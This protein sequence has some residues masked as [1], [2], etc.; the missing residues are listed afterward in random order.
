MAV[1]F[2]AEQYEKEFKPNRMQNWEIPKQFKGKVSSLLNLFCFDMP[3]YS[4]YFLFRT[5][6]H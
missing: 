6:K 5:P 3:F 1:N 2:N 4:N